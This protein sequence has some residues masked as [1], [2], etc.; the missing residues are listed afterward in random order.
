MKGLTDIEGILVG[1]ATDYEGM[2]GCTV[3]LCE[4]GATAGLDIRGSATGSSE[5]DLLSP[6]HLTEAIHAV[7][8][9]GG[10]AFGL[11]SASGVRRCSAS[12]SRASVT[13]DTGRRPKGG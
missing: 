7:V 13:R 10:S 8:L 5:L 3:V 2:T 6:G 4:R 11:E 12:R 9:T 1:H